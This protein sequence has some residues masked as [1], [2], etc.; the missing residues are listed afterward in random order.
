MEK[1]DGKGRVLYTK[2]TVE[3]NKGDK[4]TRE[5]GL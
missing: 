2:W 1:P 4:E 5:C 3:I